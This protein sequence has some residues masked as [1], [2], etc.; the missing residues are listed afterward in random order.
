MDSENPLSPTLPHVGGREL[1][2][3]AAVYVTGWLS[4]PPPNVGEG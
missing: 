2:E 1:I 4:F 3:F